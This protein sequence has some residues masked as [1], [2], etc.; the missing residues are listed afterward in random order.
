MERFRPFFPLSPEEEQALSAK[1]EIRN[2][3]RTADHL[4]KTGAVRQLAG[5]R[6]ARWHSPVRIASTAMLL[7]FSFCQ[8]D[9]S[10]FVDLL[11]RGEESP[12]APNISKPS[13]PGKISFALRDPRLV[14][15]G[16]KLA[17]F[18]RHIEAVDQIEERISLDSD[19]ELQEQGY[20]RK[21]R[22]SF[23]DGSVGDV[24]H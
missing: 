18:V 10:D 7:G 21:R 12:A 15:L 8:A 2:D 17:A 24:S 5:A 4:I 23:P 3:E 14:G 1:L 6:P 20:E 22:L 9:G 19:K 11:W 13:E 16:Y